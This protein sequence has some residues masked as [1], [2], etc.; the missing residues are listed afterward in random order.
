M[1]PSLWERVGVRDGWLA[2]ARSEEAC[3]DEQRAQRIPVIDIVPRIQASELLMSESRGPDIGCLVSIGDPGQLS[4]DG[5]ERVTQRLRLEFHDVL[6]SSAEDT[7]PCSADV[8]RLVRFAEC[9]AD[10]PRRVLV[11]CEAG[12]SR[13]TAA[14]L[15]LTPCGWVPAKRRAP[16]HVSS[17]RC[18]GHTRT[19]RWCAWPMSS[20]SAVA[21]SWPHSNASLQWP[22]RSERRARRRGPAIRWCAPPSTTLRAFTRTA[23]ET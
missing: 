23:L 1:S 18:R 4:P 5:M 2:P 17:P 21:H 13:S 11:H 14:A 3:P 20:S 22:A 7:A 16:L 12:I 9:T 8:E 15:I 19:G 10:T 6:E